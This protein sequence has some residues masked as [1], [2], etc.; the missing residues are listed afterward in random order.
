MLLPELQLTDPPVPANTPWAENKSAATINF[1]I[2]C[3]LVTRGT[4]A[5][6]EYNM[7]QGDVYEKQ[8]YSNLS[9]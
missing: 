2:F 8:M 9:I 5:G 6:D 7:P 3:S 1:F 4:I